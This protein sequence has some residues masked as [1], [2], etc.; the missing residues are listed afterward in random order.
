M[1]KCLFLLILLALLLGCSA[2][3]AAGTVP[4][5]A[6][7]TAPIPAAPAAPAIVRCVQSGGTV[8]IRFDRA[9]PREHMLSFLALDGDYRVQ[10]VRYGTQGSD[11]VTEALPSGGQWL[12][13]ELAWVDG[14]D[15]ASAVYNM[16]GGLMNRTQYDGSYNA[17]VFNAAGALT[18]Y[19]DEAS[20]VWTRF[21]EAG[22]AYCYSYESQGMRVWFDLAGTVLWATYEGDG[23]QCTW[24][25]ADGWRIEAPSGTVQVKLAL[26]P[27]A[28]PPL[29]RTEAEPTPTIEVV[30]YPNNTINLA[31]LSLQEANKKLPSKWYNVV[32]VDL[33]REGRQ[34]YFLT[35]SNARFI[36]ECYVD[37]WGDEVTVTCEIID[38]S[39]VELKSEYGRWF[40]RLSEITEDS[41][42]S[43]KNGFTF[44][45]PLSISEDLDG[46]DVAL[47][48]IRSKA[49]YRQPFRDGT[50]LTRYWRNKADWQQF[51][52]DLTQLMR[53]VEK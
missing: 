40:T 22:G 48:F 3:L 12:R 33:T 42:E 30:W 5:N 44:G 9:L 52:K 18:E 53:Y 34:T 23:Y 20:G 6:S 37:V 43:Q 32:P 50:E 8:T 27:R 10:S 14:Q 11:F 21:N 49:T 29:I 51:R 36:G 13:I 17:Y 38:R 1:K 26:D 24:D 2:A 41:I 25:A 35:V 31:G 7:E 16:A 45:V 39:G 19:R 15:N 47:L 46:A 28:V 4:L